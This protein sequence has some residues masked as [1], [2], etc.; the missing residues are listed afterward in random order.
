M[1]WM[2]I[3]V[4]LVGLTGCDITP[5]Q[6]LDKQVEVTIYDLPACID[7]FK[8]VA[9]SDYVNESSTLL[10]H[11][12]LNSTYR[13]DVSS[14]AKINVVAIDLFCMN[15]SGFHFTLNRN[16]T[17]EVTVPKNFSTNYYVNWII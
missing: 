8:H 5:Q 10:N 14:N 2:L 17:E 16:G 13:L 1:R 4:F 15:N 6:L 3:F 7:Q 12:L 9:Y 11:N